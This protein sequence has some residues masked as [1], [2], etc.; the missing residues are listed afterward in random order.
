MTIKGRI[1]RKLDKKYGKDWRVTVQ[2]VGNR[3]SKG[4]YYLYNYCYALFP[5]RGGFGGYS[6]AT[7]EILKKK[8]N[9]NEQ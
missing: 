2:S 8:V 6:D 7:I 3:R 5:K 9:K 1:Q 4:K